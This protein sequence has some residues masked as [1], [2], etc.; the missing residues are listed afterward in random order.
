MNNCLSE[1]CEI[2]DS[3]RPSVDFGIV[4]YEEYGYPEFARESEQH[5]HDFLPVRHVEVAGRF[6][7]EEK[8]DIADECPG[9]RHPLPFPA[10]QDADFGI[11]FSQEPDSVEDF[12]QPESRFDTV[13]LD[14]EHNVFPDGQVVEQEEILEHEPEVFRPEYR[15]FVIGEL[16]DVSFSDSHGAAR[17]EVDTGNDVEQGRFP[18]AARSDN[19]DDFGFADVERDIFENAQFSLRTRE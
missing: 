5:V 16:G 19:G 1:R 3:V 9:N 15:A 11:L 13:H 17:R 12:V 4:G 18:A 2:D 8:R 14:R 10:G 7:R 6:V